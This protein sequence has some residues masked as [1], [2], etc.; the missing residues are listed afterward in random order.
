MEQAQTCRGLLYKGHF[1]A[2]EI[3]GGFVSRE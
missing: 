2:G 1:G 3:R